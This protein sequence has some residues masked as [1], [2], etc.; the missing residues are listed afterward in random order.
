MKRIK[1]WFV[2][3]EEEVEIPGGIE[4]GS[5]EVPRG[6][7][8]QGPLRKLLTPYDE[9]TSRVGMR[10][11]AL[12]LHSADPFATMV[13]HTADQERLSLPL[14]P[15]I[16]YP[17]SWIPSERWL[18]PS[19]SE[20]EKHLNFSIPLGRTFATGGIMKKV[21]TEAWATVSTVQAPYLWAKMNIVGRQQFTLDVISADFDTRTQ[22]LTEQ[23]E[24]E[25]LLNATKETAI[26]GLVESTK[27]LPEGQRA[28]AYNEMLRGLGLGGVDKL[29]GAKDPEAILT[30]WI[31]ELTRRRDEIRK[32]KR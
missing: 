11:P 24:M 26:M 10:V 3:E 2:K 5:L 18:H 22:M 13:A 9:V 29:L 6:P 14:H 21:E 28:F 27:R 17:I 8:V 25:R 16:Q 30:K 12:Q 4:T 15:G 19:M 31:E 23:L 20:N 7:R 1:G 32:S